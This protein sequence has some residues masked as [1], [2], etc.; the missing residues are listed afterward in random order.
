MMSFVRRNVVD[1]T[2]Q[3]L[4]I[5]VIHNRVIYPFGGEYVKCGENIYDRRVIKISSLHHVPQVVHVVQNA[6]H[7]VDRIVFSKCRWV[8]FT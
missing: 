8:L 6:V 1:H 4:E 3:K 7:V 5:F 2:E